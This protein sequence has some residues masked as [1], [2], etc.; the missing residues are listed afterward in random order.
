MK[1]KTYSFYMLSIAVCAVMALCSVF[2]FAN[3]YDDLYQE[4]IEYQRAKNY[5]DFETPET[6]LYLFDLLYNASECTEELR[7][8]CAMGIAECLES[9]GAMNDALT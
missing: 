8:K 2:A 7:A 5:G 9:T 3:G 1:K 6:A 4:A